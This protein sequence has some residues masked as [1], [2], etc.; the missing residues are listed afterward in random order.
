MAKIT[1]AGNPINTIGELPKIGEK[2]KNFVLVAADLSET[3]LEDFKGKKLILN[4]FPSIDTGICSASARKF[5]EKASLLDNTLV[6]NISKDL[7]FA[8]ARFC[9]SEGLENVINLSD[10]R[11]QTARDYGLEIIDGPLKGLFSRAVVVLDEG[12]KVIYTEQ[13]PE[14]K[15][16]PDYDSALLVLK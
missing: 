8:L 9:A 2:V 4:F 11:G 12:N 15:Q 5:N 16:E 14:I 13:V 1:L 7:P 10:F 3:T 6:I